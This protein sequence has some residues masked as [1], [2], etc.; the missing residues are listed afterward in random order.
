MELA[1]GLKEAGSSLRTQR[2]RRA[3]EDAEILIRRYPVQA[4]L[5]GVCVGFF[6]ARMIARER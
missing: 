3:I 5:G 2:V 6:V 1:H 4:L